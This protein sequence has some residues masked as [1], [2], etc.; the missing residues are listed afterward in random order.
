[1]WW[2]SVTG[3]A[4]G[5]YRPEQIAEQHVRGRVVAATPVWRDGMAEWVAAG[6]TELAPLVGPTAP[7]APGPRTSGWVDSPE[8]ATPLTGGQP[9][10]AGP[11]HQP[12]TSWQQAPPPSWQVPTP[13]PDATNELSTAAMVCGLI[14]VLLLPIVLGPTAIICAGVALNRREPRA[15]L[16]MAI[17]IGG[18]VVGFVLGAAMAFAL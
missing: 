12:A 14:A 5:P 16:A 1:M 13:A 2:V 10:P 8:H 15:P 3:Q 6:R 7:S 18:T 4:E 17:A 9:A 11:Y